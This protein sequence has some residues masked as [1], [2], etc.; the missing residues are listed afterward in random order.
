[1]KQA[2][3]SIGQCIQHRLFDYRGVIVDVD[4][5]FLGSDDWY[6]EVAR[7]RPP[8][9]EPWYHVLVH[10]ADNETYVAE[11]NLARDVTCEPV[12][13]PLLNEFFT[14]FDQGVYHTGRHIN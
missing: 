6:N 9:N 13:H 11:R 3:F 2:K 12:N 1:M 5:E 7:S 14:D 8:K 10:D 4:A